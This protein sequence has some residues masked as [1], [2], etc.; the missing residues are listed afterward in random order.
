MAIRSLNLYGDPVPW[1]PQRTTVLTILSFLNCRKYP[2]SLLYLLMTLGPALLALAALDRGLGRLGQPLRVFGRVPLFFYL[3]Q[4]PLAH[5]LALLVATLRGE[6]TAWMFRFPPFESPEDYG[7]GFGTIYVF[8]DRDGRSTLLPVPLVF[9]FTG[10]G[11]S[12]RKMIDTIFRSLM[13]H[14]IYLN[15]AKI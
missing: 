13:D 12:K 2:P 10:P 11:N 4:W 5:G 6:P 1:T 15:P 8:W 3:L 9:P 7:H 14:P